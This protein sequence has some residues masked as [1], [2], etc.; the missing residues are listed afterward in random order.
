MPMIDVYAAAGASRTPI[1]LLEAW[2]RVE[3]VASA[4]VTTR[5]PGLRGGRRSGVEVMR[6]ILVVW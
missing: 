2:R 3:H 6:S 1:G 4:K 5:G